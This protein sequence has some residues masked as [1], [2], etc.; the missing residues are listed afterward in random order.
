MASENNV[1][2]RVNILGKYY[3]ISWVDKVDD[4]GNVGETVDSKQRILILE[5]QGFENERDTVVHECT[6]AIDYQL[7]I[8]LRERQ[9]H[10]VAAGIFS[11]LR[12]NPKLVRYLLQKSP[13][14]EQ[15]ENDAD[16][17]SHNK[18]S[19]ASTSLVQGQTA[20]I[21]GTIRA[22][23]DGKDELGQPAHNS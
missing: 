22:D 17:T 20:N 12:A 13:S 14:Q 23:K 8:G 7:Q 16:S 5:D 4:E 18:T 11:L 1:P 6:H 15:E 19:T 10:L 2:L 9:V 3:T 21:S